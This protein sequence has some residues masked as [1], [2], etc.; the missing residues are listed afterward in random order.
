MC[1]L[2]M[3]RLYNNDSTVTSPLS[4][5]ANPNNGSRD[6]TAQHDSSTTRRRQRS[7]QPQL[8]QTHFP[9][10][11]RHSWSMDHT[12][13]TSIYIPHLA[14]TV[15]ILDISSAAPHLNTMLQQMWESQPRDIHPYKF[16][17]SL[18]YQHDANHRGRNCHRRLI[19]TI[20]IP[21]GVFYNIK[22]PEG[23]FYTIKIP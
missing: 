10:I 16:N 12:F 3:L 21:E 5:Q 2:A 18:E 22:I 8:P 14:D 7:S 11:D 17:L 15:Q 4:N 19:Y 9:L 1:A 23:V 20:K 13:V 6:Q